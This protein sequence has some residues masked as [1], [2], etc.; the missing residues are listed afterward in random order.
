MG[1][2]ANLPIIILIVCGKDFFRLWQP[3][4]NA[5]QL[6]IL[7]LLTCAGLILNGGI[8]CIYDIF[9]VVNKLKLNAIVLFVSG[10][11]S[12][13]VVFILLKTTDL[14]IY[15]VAG[16]STFIVSMKNLFIIVP[17]AAKCLGLKWNAFYGD[18]FRP[19]LF[20]CLGSVL[21]Y[22][23]IKIIPGSGWISL[24]VSACLTGIISLMIGTFIFLNK[25]E[26]RFL[27]E[28][29]LKNKKRGR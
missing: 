26:R 21:S 1:V 11:I 12:T 6:E 28:K 22:F 27:I 18:V 23:L 24:I 13:G 15:A 17:Y 4:Q 25:T 3:T 9:T 20:V 7:S 2:L 14:G 10:L 5:E 29:L 16:V 19:V 8:N